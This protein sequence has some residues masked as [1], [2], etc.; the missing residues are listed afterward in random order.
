MHCARLLRDIAPR[1]ASPRRNS[2]DCAGPLSGRRLLGQEAAHQFCLAVLTLEP[3]CSGEHAAGMP[4]TMMGLILPIA[5]FGEIAQGA[6]PGKKA[7]CTAA[8][9]DKLRKA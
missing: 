1:T 6:Q 5:G 7:V 2:A 4:F 8:H 9:G 3:R